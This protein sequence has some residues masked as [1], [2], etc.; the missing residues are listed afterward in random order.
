MTSKQRVVVVCPGRGTYNKPELGYL[1]RYHSDKTALL[2]TIDAYRRDQGQPSVVELDSAERY[3]MATHTAGEHASALIYACAAGDFADIDRDQYEIVAVT[4]N[5][6]G[7]YIALATAG[8]LSPA[9]GI[10]V[11]NTMGSMM[12][13]GVIGGQLIY[14]VCNADWH[15]DSQHL[16]TL[17]Q[18]MR[19]VNADAAHQVYVS[20]RLG[21]YWVIAGNDSGLKAL[22][23]VLP[24]IDDTYPMRLHNHAAFHSPLL[25]E[26]SEKGRAALPASG[27]NPPQIPMVDGRGHIWQP[28]ATD[29][30]ALW[31]Y[32]LGHQVV[33]TYDFTRAIAV[34]IKEFAPDKLI[35]LGPGATL[36][37][38]IAQTL[39]QHRWWE[40]GQKSD[41]I[42]RQKTDPVVLAMGI[43]EQRALATGK[44]AD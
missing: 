31:D 34:S 24:R 2:E 18:A 44:P 27:F 32:T 3:S 28:H 9:S 14:P 36:G 4:G 17:Q 41:F 16:R 8:A 26:V 21:G 20:I 23:K 19:E 6:M 38:A 25:A 10:D 15:L 42:A 39:I 13:D 33:E 22:E 1:G 7:W 29:T 30:Q 11:I 12:K 43:P 37:G 5:S 35:V 40:L